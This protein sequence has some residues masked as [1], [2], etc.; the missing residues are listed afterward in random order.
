MRLVALSNCLANILWKASDTDSRA[1]ALSA[2]KGTVDTAS[3]V[4][5]TVESKAEAAAEKI[6]EWIP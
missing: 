6:R 4:A 5:S 1:M 2:L 3:S